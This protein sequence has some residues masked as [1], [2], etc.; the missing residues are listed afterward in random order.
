MNNLFSKLNKLWRLSKQKKRIIVTDYRTRSSGT[1]T[2]AEAE[3]KPKGGCCNQRLSGLMGDVAKISFQTQSHS[4]HGYL[5][6]KQQPTI[7]NSAEAQHAERVPL[8]AQKKATAKCSRS[9]GL[10]TDYR[11]F[12]E[13][14]LKCVEFYNWLRENRYFYII[15]NIICLTLPI[16]IGIYL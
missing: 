9:C 8:S 7:G 16:Q 6:S 12:Y 13:G 3:S 1:R 11:T 14:Y 10:I 2:A 4:R 5:H 15:C